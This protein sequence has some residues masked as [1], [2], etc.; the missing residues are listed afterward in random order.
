MLLVFKNHK[1]DITFCGVGCYEILK[2]KRVY[3]FPFPSNWPLF[4]FQ[5]LIH[6]C[7]QYSELMYIDV[8]NMVLLLLQRHFCC[9]VL[10]G[11]GGTIELSD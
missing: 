11:G 7:S 3:T 6:G 5:V 1:T 10:G 9:F 2:K 4:C 8:I